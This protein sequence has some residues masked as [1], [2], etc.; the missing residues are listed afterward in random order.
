MTTHPETL[1]HNGTVYF[2]IPAVIGTMEQINTGELPKLTVSVANYQ[3]MAFKWARDND[4]SLN[5]VV[6]K[7][8]NIS[9]TNSGDWDSVKMQIVG[10]IFTE[11][12]AQFN[13]GW[14]INYDSMG[15][16]RIWNRRDFPGIPFNW[17]SFAVINNISQ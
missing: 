2:P 15:P 8:V 7:F 11:E 14:N 1:T 16:R 10:S 5:D 12:T 3:G 4:L 9:L 17:R 13:L 6:I